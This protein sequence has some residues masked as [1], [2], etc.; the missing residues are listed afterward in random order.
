MAG[1][2]MFWQNFSESARPVKGR[3]GK[4]AELISEQPSELIVGW[5]GSPPLTGWRVST[6][7]GPYLLSVCTGMYMKKSGTAQAKP[8]VS[9]GTEGFFICL[10]DDPG[11]WASKWI[12]RCTM[13]LF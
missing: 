1:L 11:N 13:A 6:G 5:A 4:Q 8:F 2:L 9:L 7:M 10:F 12:G 3:K